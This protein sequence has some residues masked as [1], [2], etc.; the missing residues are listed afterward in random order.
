LSDPLAIRS[1]KLIVAYDG[2]A[3]QGWQVQLDAPTIQAELQRALQTLTNESVRVTASGRT[4]AGVHALGQV[5]SFDSSTSH[6]PDTIL[7]ALNA[8][9]PH[10]IRVLEV[11]VA[12]DGFHAIRDA[13]S[14]RYRYCIQDGGV[15]DPFLRGL[16]WHLPQRMDED[17]LRAAANLLLGKHDFASYQ[18]AG[19]PRASTVR[20]I[21]DFTVTRQSRELCD[22]IVMEIAADGFL[23]NMVRNLV[24]TLVEVGRGSRPIQWPHEVLTAKD[25]TLAGSTAPPHGLFL[26]A[27][28]Y[29]G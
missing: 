19:S 27:V 29:V 17:A 12:A 13:V 4:D 8:N 9:L 25:R 18:A 16:C 28:E 3:Y 23:Y 2:T 5:V 15:A 1:F 14:K 22:L 21:F 20:T 10:D 26:V 11:E 7:R 24:G 6:S